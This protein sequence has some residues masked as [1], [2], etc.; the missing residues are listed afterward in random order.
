MPV[1]AVVLTVTLACLLCLLNIGSTT[2][3]VFN[4]I[5]SLCCW[6]IYLSYAICISSLIY[7]RVV[8]PNLKLGDWNLGR[9]GLYVNIFALVYTLWVM[10]ILPF[11]ST[12]PVTPSN[13]NYCGP[14][15]I[16][17]LLFIA[18]MWFGW[19]RKNWPGPNLTIRDFIL[20]HS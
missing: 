4:A 17:I 18:V 12:V 14:I 6:A 11:P 2:Y 19:A 15:V 8:N 16:V 9:A 1:R 20:A 5:T 3:I 7:A 13:M 10:V